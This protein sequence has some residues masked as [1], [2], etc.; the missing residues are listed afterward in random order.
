MLFRPGGRIHSCWLGDIVAELGAAYIEG[1]CVANP[2]FT[3]AAQECLLKTRIEQPDPSRGLFC[4][5][6]GRAINFPTSITAYHTFKHITAQAAAL[7]MLACERNHGSLLNFIG[8]R[9]QQEIQNF[10]EEQR[11]TF[12]YNFFAIFFKI[13]KLKFLF[14]IEVFIL[15]FLKN[16]FTCLFFENLCLIGLFCLKRDDASRVMY[17]L[18]NALRCRCGQDLSLISANQYG[19]FLEIPGRF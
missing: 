7:S 9:I 10:P 1:A 3:L 11:L 4:T 16:V 6:D 17:G 18:V 12:L 2:A 8:L 14:R 19:T 13:T 5:S 15:F